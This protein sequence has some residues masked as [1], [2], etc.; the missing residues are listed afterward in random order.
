MN[1]RWIAGL[2][3]ALASCTNPP[4]EKVVLTFDPDHFRRNPGWS[5]PLPGSV[6]VEFHAYR[7]LPYLS[8]LTDVNYQSL[9]IEVPVRVNGK[10]LTTGDAPIFFN[11]K[12]G[13][14][15]S[16]RNI[17]DPNLMAEDSQEKVR[18]ASDA[19]SDRADL[20]LAAGLV[21][22]TP[23]CR[24]WDNQAP[25][26]NYYG[27]A[28]AAIVDLKA[29]IRYLRFNQGPD[30]RQYR[31]NHH[32]RLQCRGRLICLTGDLRGQPLIYIP[33][34]VGWCSRSK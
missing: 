3:M 6:D 17:P 19:L 22:V 29:A 7:H 31:P 30:T 18:P 11:I 8:R 33:P 24:G 34:E 9:D 28:P 26:G 10:E 13:G 4:S 15:L 32:G 27:K 5:I 14:Y 21:V 12:V 20:A 16:V 23:G 2:F 25:D 1:C